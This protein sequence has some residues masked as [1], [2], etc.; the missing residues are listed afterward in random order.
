VERVAPRTPLEETLVAAAAEVLDRRP[1]DVGVLDNFF[2]LGGHSLLA[3]R[4]VSL[5]NVRHGIEIPLQ[6][7]FETANLAELADRIVERELSGADDEMLASLLAEM[8]TPDE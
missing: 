5:L 2:D 8:E 6:L 1:E 4:F 3:T 7:V